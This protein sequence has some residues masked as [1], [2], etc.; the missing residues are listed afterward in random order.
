MLDPIRNSIANPANGPGS[1]SGSSEE[2]EDGERSLFSINVH[3]LLLVE[4]KV[5][6]FT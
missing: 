3:C 1:R 2:E 6:K 5:G 4:V